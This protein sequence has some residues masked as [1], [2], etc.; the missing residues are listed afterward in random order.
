[1]IVCQETSSC[2]F[3]LLSC[4]FIME[5]KQGY[6]LCK[7]T[8]H[9]LLGHDSHCCPSPS[10]MPLRRELSPSSSE[11]PKTCTNQDVKLLSVQGQVPPPPTRHAFVVPTSSFGQRCSLL[12]LCLGTGTSR[13]AYVVLMWHQH[14]AVCGV[15]KETWSI[16]VGTMWILLSV[17]NAILRFC[18]LRIQAR[19]LQPLMQFAWMYSELD[20]SIGSALLIWI[21]H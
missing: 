17:R 7:Y 21:Q 12:T 18:A 16:V 6:R 1:M 14:G 4:G 13:L 20:R 5:S 3:S 9:A 15:C 2:L 19:L 11:S 10:R 8:V